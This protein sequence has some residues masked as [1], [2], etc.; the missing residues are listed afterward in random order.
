ME[1]DFKKEIYTTPD[2]LKEFSIARATFYNWQKAWQVQGGDLSDMGKFTLKGSSR[3]YWVIKKFMSWLIEHQVNEK[4]TFDYEQRDQQIAI[5]VVN[6][7]RR[8]KN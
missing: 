4:K 7:V 6:N 2:L 8:K 1:L 5:G 3:S